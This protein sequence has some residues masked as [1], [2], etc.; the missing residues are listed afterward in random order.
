MTNI[1]TTVLPISAAKASALRY[2]S[3]LRLQDIL[4][5]QGPPLLGAVFAIRHPQ[6]HDLA[7][8]A[9]LTAANV[10]LMTHV[11]MLNDWAG[12]TDDLADPNK[13]AGVFTARG[14]G[15]REISALTAALLVVSLL[16]FSRL[17]AVTLVLSLAIA[18]LS[19]LYS[20][21]RFHWKGRPLLNSLTHLAGGILHFLLGYSLGGAID[22]RG[23]ATA[24]FFALIFTAGH[25]TQEIRDYHADAVNGIRTN[26]VIFGQRRTFAASL[27]LFTL[28]QGL[29]LLLALQ[30]ILPR[31]LAALVALYLIQLDWSRH[32]LRDGLHYASVCRLQ[33]RYRALYAV[34]GLAM[35][36]ALYLAP[37]HDASVSASTKPAVRTTG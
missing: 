18:T 1:T 13:A 9:T 3:C 12:L 6:A 17:G 15:R 25:L 24:A 19:A 20:F 31:S 2:F 4:V 16:L 10:L 23:L 34:I 5:L 36:A 32:A 26:A 29:F 30:G 37:G 8:L 33:A 7:P 21:P 22:G 35:A 14:V 27:A 11:F 28:A